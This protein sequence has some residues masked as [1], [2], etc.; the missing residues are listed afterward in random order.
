MEQTEAKVGMRVYFGRSHGEQTLGEIIK[1]NRAKLRVKQ[2]EKRGAIR[3]Y[4]IGTLWTVA[5]TL[6]SIVKED[7]K[8]V[9]KL[10]M[11]P[12]ELTDKELVAQEL[13]NEARAARREAAFERRANR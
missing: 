4:P 11:P 8:T 12:R 5:A 2:L 9:A 3:D 10:T 1:V 7:G 6:C 13:R